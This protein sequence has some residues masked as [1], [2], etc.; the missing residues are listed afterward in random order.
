[1]NGL[2]ILAHSFR[3]VSGNLGMAIKV[4]GWL[5][6]LYVI[7]GGLLMWQMPDWMD[8]AMAQDPQSMVNAADLSGGSVGLV[9]VG[10]LVAAIFL[11]WSISLVAIVWH[12]YILLEE[13]PRGLIPYRSDFHVGRYFWYGAG[14]SLL[15][16]LAVGVVTIFLGMIFGP[17]FMGSMQGMATG[18]SAG[19]GGVSLL[20]GIVLGT[21]IAVLYLRM[22]LILPAV[23]LDESLTIGQ[24]WA[25]TSG[26]TGAILSLALALAF[27][28]AVVPLVITLAFGELVWINMLLTGLYQ[29]FYFMLGISILSTLYGVIVQ[30]REVY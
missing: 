20:V 30:K 21:I 16:A 14:I 25:Q 9:F 18:Q 6:V 19:L 3:Q 27:I 23:A 4:S 17:F 8:A 29:W 11:L 26:Y 22:A 12:R 28:N 10:M 5:V 1:M 24:A 13:V 7:G 2:T 15:A